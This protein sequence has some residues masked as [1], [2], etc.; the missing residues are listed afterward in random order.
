MARSPSTDGKPYTNPEV[1]FERSDVTA[2]GIL[3][4]GAGLAGGLVVVILAMLWFGRAM[5]TRIDNERK[6]ADL[7]PAHVDKNRLP[8][9]PRLEAWEDVRQKNVQLFPPRASGYLK[10][11]RELLDEGNA[12]TGV[13]PI[14]TAIDDLAGKLP[15]RK[16]EKSSAGGQ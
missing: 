3:T 16:G 4:F 13:L 7:P 8:P 10:S 6:I 12:K 9:E 1:R 11:Q 2:G 14:R 5:K 15:V